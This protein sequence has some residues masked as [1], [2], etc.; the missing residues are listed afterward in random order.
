MRRIIYVVAVAVAAIAFYSQL[1]PRAQHQQLHSTVAGAEIGDHFAPSEN[2][3]RLDLEHIQQAQRTLDIAMF[4]FTDRY[5]AEALVQLARRGV[6]VRVYRDRSQ[7]EQ[8]LRNADHQHEH[9]ITDLFHAQ[10]NIQIR[11]KNSNEH[12]LMHLKAY[13]VDGRVLRDGSA[14]WSPAGLKHQDNNAHFTSD[15]AQVHAFQ[16]AFEEMWN[17]PSNHQVQ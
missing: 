4:S 8:E 14:N 7:F 16:Q 17:R 5:L 12:N 2:V 11:V 9:S 3:E 6:H 13:L 10:P 1:R 15:A